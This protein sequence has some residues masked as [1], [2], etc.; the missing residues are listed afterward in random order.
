LKPSNPSIIHLGSWNVCRAW[1]IF[2]SCDKARHPSLEN[3][4]HRQ[5]KTLGIGPALIVW[6][7]HEVQDAY[8]PHMNKGYRSS[9][10][11]LFC[12]WFSL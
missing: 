10:C 5:I 3:R 12:P 1:H 6:Y 8:L 4:L 7:L 11:M 2:S 9:P